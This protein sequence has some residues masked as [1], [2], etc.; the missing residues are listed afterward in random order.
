[1]ARVPQW[2]GIVL[3]GGSGTRLHPLTLSVSKQLM[4]IYDKP[5]V[6]YPIS[7]L[8]MAGVS[9]IAVISTP[10]DLPLFRRLLGA[11]GQWGCSFTYIE[12]PR[13]EGI[14]QAFILARS[15]LRGSP[16]CLVLGDNVFFGNN[17]YKSLQAATEHSRGATIFGYRVR[18]PQRYGVVSF[19][20]DGRAVS[21]E[22]KPADPKSN[23]AVTGLYFYDAEVTDIAASITPSARG[24]LEITDVNNVYLRRGQLRVERLGRGMAW[25]D[26]GTHDS[27]LSA[28]LFVQTVEQRQGLKVSCPEE[29]AW[30]Q[31]FIDTEQLLRLAEALRKNAYGQYL[32]E[33]AAEDRAKKV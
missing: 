5:M 23:Y 31:G 8:L 16:C 19:D 32:L 17:L 4:P 7:T 29:I 30:R 2:K 33:L 1:M 10:E 27:L 20:A 6:Y 11:G 9:D 25:L 28:S 22:E 18:D 3:A 24:E 12:Q 21:I 14:A 26:T 15:F 13:P